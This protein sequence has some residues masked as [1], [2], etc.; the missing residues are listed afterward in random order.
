MKKRRKSRAEEVDQSTAR[1]GFAF[2]KCSRMVRVGL[3]KKVNF[4]LLLFIYFFFME[5]GGG[6]TGHS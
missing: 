6:Q 5:I 1:G 3:I 4:L 2:F